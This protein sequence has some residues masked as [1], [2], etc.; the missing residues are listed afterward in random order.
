MKSTTAKPAPAPA[1]VNQDDRPD[2]TLL[3]HIERTGGTLPTQS[4]FDAWCEEQSIRK[5]DGTG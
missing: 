3:E 2:E 4:E 5:D 1:Q